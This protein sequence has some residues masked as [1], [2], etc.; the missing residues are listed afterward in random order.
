M[1]DVANYLVSYQKFIFTLLPITKLYETRSL[2]YLV[3]EM[4]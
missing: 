3:S 2:V 4:A 1:G